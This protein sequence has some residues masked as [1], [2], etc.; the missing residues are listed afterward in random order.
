MALRVKISE[1]YLYLRLYISA[2]HP[3]QYQ[4][5]KILS[6]CLFELISRMAGPF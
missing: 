3:P 1:L 4:F 5:S 2:L 6:V